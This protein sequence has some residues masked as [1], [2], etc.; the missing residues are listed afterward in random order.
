M[1]CC[2]RHLRARACG[3]WQP[4]A[5]AAATA[6]TV[7]VIVSNVPIIEDDNDGERFR[8]QWHSKIQHAHD[9][10]TIDPSS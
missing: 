2:W 8:G 4:T 5:S 6:T 9:P 3:W 7:D 10:D 1:S